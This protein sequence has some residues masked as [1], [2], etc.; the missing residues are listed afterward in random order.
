MVMTQNT[1]VQILGLFEGYSSVNYKLIEGDQII[2]HKFSSIAYRKLKKRED[3]KILFFLPE[4]SI[5]KDLSSVEMLRESPDALMNSY[6]TKLRSII[7]DDVEFQVKILPSIGSYKI[8][9]ESEG[10]GSDVILT[11]ENYIENIIIKILCDLIDIE[12]DLMIDISTG[13]NIYIHALI[14][15]VRSLMVYK[16]LKKILQ[17]QNK[18]QFKVECMVVPP[19]LGIPD[20]VFPIEI[21]DYR[22]KVFFNIP[23]RNMDINNNLITFSIRDG[24]SFDF[25]SLAKSSPKLDPNSRRIIYTTL[26]SF[27]AVKYNSPLAFFSNNLIEFNVNNQYL[28]K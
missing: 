6:E 3:I 27:N 10:R 17:L 9:I 16:K 5:I 19:V 20:Q 26:L 1:I 11:F 24:S 23:Y 14:E 12:G 4:S 15:A 28:T 2:C 21:Y 8:K 25:E 22:A 18:N 7:G 13:F